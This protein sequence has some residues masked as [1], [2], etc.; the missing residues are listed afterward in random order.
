MKDIVLRAGRPIPAIGFGTWQITPSSK[1]KEMVAAALKAGY[2]LIDTAKIYGNED[3]V[4]EAI[5]ESGI[6]RDDLFITTKLW[7]DDQGFDHTLKACKDSLRNLG[8][9]YLDLYLIHWPATKKRHDSWRAMEKLV[10][11]GLIKDAGVSNY[12]VAHIE[13]LLERSKMPPAVN[14][15]EFHPFI[16]EQQKEIFDY[17]RAQGIVV[18]AYSPVNRVS[19]DSGQPIREIAGKL[20]KTPQQVA[21]R[22]C[23]QHQTVPLPRSTSPDHLRSNI[24]IDDFELSTNDMKILDSLSDGERVTW[25]P[26]GM[27]C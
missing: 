5:R 20:D 23:L 22:W 2:R 19:S 27:S 21:L 24:Q 26:A 13:S 12:T 8:L 7:N 14:Q 17:C 4:G 15:I 9:D 3:G 1:A 10:A 11:D 6:P 18:E 25:D 16:Y